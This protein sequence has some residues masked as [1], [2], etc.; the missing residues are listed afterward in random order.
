MSLGFS[1]WYKKTSNVK[2]E[3]FCCTEPERVLPKFTTQTSKS[4]KENQ[5]FFIAI[6]NDNF[7]FPLIHIEDVLK[8]CKD[9]QEKKKKMFSVLPWTGHL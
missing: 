1:F 2:K 8:T 7:V 5:N 3:S 9:V 4:K 6:K